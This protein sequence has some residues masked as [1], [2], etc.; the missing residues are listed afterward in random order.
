MATIPTLTNART[1]KLSHRLWQIDGFQSSRAIPRYGRFRGRQMREMELIPRFRGCLPTCIKADADVNAHLLNLPANCFCSRSSTPH[2]ISSLG[3]PCYRIA[4][5]ELLGSETVPVFMCAA[6]ALVVSSG[7][8]AFLPVASCKFPSPNPS[9]T[10]RSRAL[11][12]HGPICSLRTGVAWQRFW[13]QVRRSKP[14]HWLWM[15]LAHSH[16]QT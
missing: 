10:F 16:L 11:C 7:P 6:A 4:S 8:L 14:L 3:S 9:C 1:Y 2:L 13:P 5:A 15:R 12:L